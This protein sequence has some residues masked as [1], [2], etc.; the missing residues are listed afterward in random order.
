MPG[1]S[2]RD[3]FVSQV[4]PLFCEKIGS[5]CENSGTPHVRYVGCGQKHKFVKFMVKVP[6]RRRPRDLCLQSPIILIFRAHI[7]VDRQTTSF[8]EILNI[9]RRIY[10][11]V[12]QKVRE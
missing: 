4:N 12:I 10:A 6:F 3:G 7:C 2:Q 1:T 5:F 8:I 11:Y 9:G